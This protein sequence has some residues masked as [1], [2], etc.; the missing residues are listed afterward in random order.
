MDVVSDTRTIYKCG[1]KFYTY[2]ERKNLEINDLFIDLRDCQ[3]KVIESNHDIWDMSYVAPELY[4]IMDEVTEG[5][6]GM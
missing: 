1:N 5:L 3:F 4:I 6:D 2:S